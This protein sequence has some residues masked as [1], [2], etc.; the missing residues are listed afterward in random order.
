MTRRGFTLATAAISLALAAAPGNAQR[1]K[2]WVAPRTPDGH[3]DLQGNWSN[4][5][6]TTLERPAGF[7]RALTQEQVTR[8]EKN[9]ADDIVKLAKQSDPD[10]P[11]PPK[12]GDGSTGAYGNV[13]GYNYFWI[14]AG[15]H[16]AIVNGERRSSFIVDP[17]DGRVPAIT[18]EGRQLIADRRQRAAQFRE[19]DN[20]ENR[21]LAERCIMSFGSNAGPPMLPN[22]F[23]NNNYTVVQTKDHVAIMT[24]MVHDT[25]LIRMGKAEPVP[26]QV[27][28]WMGVSYGRWE[29]DTLVVETTNQHPQQWNLGASAERLVGFSDN[30]KVIE[31]F[32]RADEHTML[33][34]FTIIDP[35]MFTKPW[36]GEVPFVKMDERIYEYACHEANYALSNILSG[37]RAREREAA[38]K[39]KP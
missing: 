14:D 3:P 8:L 10:R 29:G 21:P 37:E 32:H 17:P 7:P 15:D 23:Y 36:S 13:G 12:G 34:R 18:A 6:L 35:T 4:A 24:E 39:P 30:L 5:S 19:Y 11:A 1:A 27:R 9:R 33:Y 22:Y 2:A 28:P 16:V 26:N 31:R 20:P 38:Q 25:R